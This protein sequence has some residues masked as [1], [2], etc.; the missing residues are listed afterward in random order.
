MALEG[1][2]SFFKRF[3]SYQMLM[4]LFYLLNV[5]FWCCTGLIIDSIVHS[6][7]RK[8]FI[9]YLTRIG[10]V[11]CVI[12]LISVILYTFQN[13]EKEISKILKNPDR[14]NEQSVQIAV[15]KSAKDGYGNKYV[16]EM[17]AILQSINSEEAYNSTRNSTIYALG[18]IG[19]PNSIKALIEHYN[20]P[21]DISYALRMNEDTILSMLDVNQ[22][23]DM[24]N[25][26]IEAAKLLEFRSF[27]Q[28]LSK[29]KNNYLSK[30]TQEL[31]SKVLQQISQNPQEN[32]PKF[33]ID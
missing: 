30:E 7:K 21:R 26:G 16:D 2:S 18:I 27:I 1:Y 8:K 28:P 14:Y 17:I 15:I 9:V 20:V 5:F 6:S 3:L 32:N 11:S 4:W 31:A 23:Q 13:S 29:I 24:I 12:L 22:P 33:N 25:A 19:T 10:I